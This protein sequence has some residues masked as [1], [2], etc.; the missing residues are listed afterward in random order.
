MIQR[1]RL[2]HWLVDQ[3]MTV[4]SLARQLSFTRNYVSGMLNGDFPISPALIG[5]FA[6]AFGYDVAASVFG[7][8]VP[9]PREQDK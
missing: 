8:S 3:H 5:K 7:E 6:Q 2:R 4:T 9:E 1:L